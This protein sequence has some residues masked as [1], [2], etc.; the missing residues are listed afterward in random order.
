M[1]AFNNPVFRNFTLSQ[2][3]F[4]LDF[5]VCLSRDIDDYFECS[6]KKKK[7]TGAVG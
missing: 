5:L 3:A 6:T 7:G 2:K 1:A 4:S